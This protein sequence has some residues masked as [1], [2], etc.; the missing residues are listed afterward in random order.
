MTR[1]EYALQQADQ[2]IC[3]LIREGFGLFLIAELYDVPR[4]RY[5]TEMQADAD[6]NWQA[7][8]E[9][10]KEGGHGVMTESYLREALADQVEAILEKEQGEVTWLDAQRA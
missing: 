10:I 1:R 2:E 9:L 7:L 8:P 6:L 5:C 4:I 3:R